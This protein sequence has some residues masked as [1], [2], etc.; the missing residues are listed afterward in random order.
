[1]NRA[2]IIVSLTILASFSHLG[3]VEAQDL[4]ARMDSIFTHAAPDLTGAARTLLDLRSETAVDTGR[5]DAL[6]GALYL[7]AGSTDSARATLT[8]AV[9]SRPDLAGVRFGL[10]RVH[11][12]LR[13]KPKDAIP[14]LLKAIEIDSTY[15]QAHSLLAIAYRETD[16]VRKARRAADRAITLDPRLPDPYR[17][18]AEIYVEDG[19]TGAAGIFFRHYLDRKPGDQNA[20]FEFANDLF[21]AGAYEALLEIAVRLT[22]TRSLPLLG[23]ALVQ[24]GDHEGA[25]KAYQDY[26]ASLDQEG[27]V[28]YEDISL[29]SNRRE[30]RAWRSVPPSK[31][32]A[33]LSRFW[34]VRDPFKTSGGA[35]RRAEHY[36]RVWVARAKYGKK[37]KP[38]DRR[39]EVYIRFGEPTWKSSSR[40]MNAVVPSAVQTVQER[41]AYALYGDQGVD[42]SYVGPVFPIK[43]QPDLGQSLGETALVGGEL[44]MLDSF[45]PITSGHDWS[46]IP[47]E[48]WIYTG[49]G[50]GGI[51]V[52]FTDDFLSGNFDYAPIPTMSE[53]D[54]D[55][56]SRRS[57]G[58][59]VR[60][61]SILT[62]LAPSARIQ[63]V[64][65]RTPEK[66]DLS[67][68]TSLDFRYEAVSFRG[69]EEGL[70]E[71][72]VSVAL[73]IDEI[74]LPTDRDTSVV[75]ERRI[76]L[77]KNLDEVHR[78]IDYLGVGINDNTRGR[79]MLAVDGHRVQVKPGAY[80]LRIQAQRTNTNRTEV[81]PQGIDLPDYWIEE[82]ILSDLQIAQR[83]TESV[84]EPTK[85]TRNGFEILPAPTRQFRKGHPLFVYYEI[86]NLKSDEFGQTRFQLSYEV[87]AQTSEGKIKIPF[88]AKLRKTSG[89]SVGFEFEQTGSSDSEND[90][91]EI[92]LADAKPGRYE[93][94]MKITD[95]NAGTVAT[96][97]A[98]FA[99]IP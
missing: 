19:N 82:L 92:Q 35:F 41:L 63:D 57:T 65:I 42:F 53:E 51:E 62:D 14:V 87:Q 79:G 31:R 5:V 48:V 22:E 89:E 45:K 46:A 68:L 17:L 36:R 74:A 83:I 1:M 47:W 80:E 81:Y 93:V 20:A 23:F 77:L 40:D 95:L 55:R 86:Y 2:L 76:V 59:P 64:I 54:M 18:L 94:R 88:L 10:G 38:W 69:D 66:Y 98:K 50:E 33:F 52:A 84:A 39:G 67:F 56:I 26:I 24:K 58:S 21:E 7:R 25:L 28:L 61:L 4:D 11:L 90:Y 16:Q 97:Q 15:A 6:M 8:R 60:F 30:L 49:L 70:T 29:V 85:W 71:L 99:V 3:R 73:P 72:Q 44:L 34:M 37:K 13:K 32:E 12:E 96:R 75:V 91:L 27:R 43:S 78:S 9:A